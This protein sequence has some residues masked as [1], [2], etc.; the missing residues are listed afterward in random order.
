MISKFSLLLTSTL[1]VTTGLK[2]AQI[3]HFDAESDIKA[4]IS[5]T[6]LT[7]LMVEGDRI[8]DVFLVGATLDMVPD[9][10]LGHLYIK[11][12]QHL[13]K[14]STMSSNIRM[15]ITTEAGHAQDFTLV[16]HDG[17]AQTII[18][19]H[20]VERGHRAEP[21]QLEAGHGFRGETRTKTGADSQQAELG[22][23]FKE[24]PRQ[25]SKM[26]E[27][28][29]QFQA[30]E[31]TNKTSAERLAE[32]QASFDYDADWRKSPV[33]ENDY[34]KREYDL[35]KNQNSQD[36]QAN[37]AEPG[38][39]IGKES[40]TK[41]KVNSTEDEPIKL[42]GYKTQEEAEA[43]FKE[44][45][46]DRPAH[47]SDLGALMVSDELNHFSEDDDEELLSAEEFGKFG[48]AEIQR[49]MQTVKELAQAFEQGRIADG[50]VRY[51]PTSDDM[52]S[53][54]KKDDI[55]FQI[56]RYVNNR[57]HPVRLKEIDFYTHPSIKYICLVNPVV[58][59]GAETFILKVVI[60]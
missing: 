57:N 53:L 17:D 8:V 14:D 9:E 10:R 12:T 15:T 32:K 21:G 18:L 49:V 24:V 50:F 34:W 47:L 6:E 46:A 13:S 1:L 27:T 58:E 43:V 59:S 19:K 16:P 39:I 41:D 3:V 2:A 45:F 55:E 60:K 38:P 35:A 37:Q 31:S 11:P 33:S 42:Y 23:R 20:P 26:D 22:D 25:R 30:L 36:E 54:L 7:R 28:N 51:A 5:N 29:N 56:I 4:K 52:V 40:S 48:T 44:Q